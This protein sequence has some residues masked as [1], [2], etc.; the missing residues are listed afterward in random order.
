MACGIDAKRKA[1]G[2]EKISRRSITK[3]GNSTVRSI[4]VECAMRW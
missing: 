1:R 4:L 3:Q 2:E